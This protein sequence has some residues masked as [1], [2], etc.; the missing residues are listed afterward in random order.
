MKP[1]KW[2]T[3]YPHGTKQGDEELKFFISLARNPKFQW[4]S[5]SAIAKESGLTKEKVEEIISKY[6]KKGMVFQ[7]PK[8]EDQYGYWER[9][10]EMLPDDKKS[11]SGKDQNDRVNKVISKDMV[12]HIDPCVSNDTL[13]N[14]VTLKT[15]Y[16]VDF[17]MKDDSCQMNNNSWK[18]Q[19]VKE[20]L[21]DNVPE[22]VKSQWL[23]T[24]PQVASVTDPG[25]ANFAPSPC[26]DFSCEHIYFDEQVG[27]KS[28]WIKGDDG[29]NQRR[30]FYIDMANMPLEKA[31]KFM[32]NL[33][34][35]VMAKNPQIMGE[36]LGEKEDAEYF[37]KKL[38]TALNFPKSTGFYDDMKIDNFVV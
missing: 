32:E 14:F 30:V 34:T 29:P 21:A 6:H 16:G 20:F 36:N 22:A 23:V 7:N 24:T 17:Q 27:E 3:V 5:T 13:M 28:E 4:R 8:N 31:E 2:T 37:R 35:Q 11:I 9:V 26:E 1:P 15:G 38:F 12:S 10:P 18:Q 25:F 19:V 33:K